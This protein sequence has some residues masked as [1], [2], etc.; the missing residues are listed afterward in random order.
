MTVSTSRRQATV[1]NAGKGILV[2]TSNRVGTFDEGFKSRIQLAIQYEKLTESSRG[3]VWENF[4][5]RLETFKSDDIDIRD[6]R[7]HLNDLAHYKMN[8]R[9]IRNA[10]TTGRQLAMFKKKPLDYECLKHVINVSSRFDR[11][12]TAINEGMEDEDLA[13]EDHFR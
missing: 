6:L 5:N 11:Y 10:V 8:G 9:Q 3:R 1:T 7:R 4:I 13:R 12:L 2:L